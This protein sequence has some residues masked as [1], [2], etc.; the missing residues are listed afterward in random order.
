MLVVLEGVSREVVAGDGMVFR[1]IA[2]GGEG[3]VRDRVCETIYQDY[4]DFPA[5][6]PRTDLYFMETQSMRSFPLNCALSS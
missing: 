4:Q 1:R 3:E 2:D 5:F 6:L